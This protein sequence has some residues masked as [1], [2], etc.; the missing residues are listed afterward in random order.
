M[1]VGIVTGVLG[2]SLILALLFTVD[3]T[4]PDGN[5]QSTA[6][7]VVN[8]TAG[9]TAAIGLGWYASCVAFF[10][11]ICHVPTGKK[12]RIGESVTYISPSPPSLD[13]SPCL[14]LPFMFLFLW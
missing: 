8:Q 7:E 10:C 13:P 14:Y 2:L 12:N 3:I 4:D 6:I 9:G 11:G 5:N 1:Y